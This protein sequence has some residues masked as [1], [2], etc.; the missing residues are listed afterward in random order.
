MVMMHA[1]IVCAAPDE[2]VPDLRGILFGSLASWALV[3]GIA[4]QLT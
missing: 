4:L 1:A 2:R 3:L